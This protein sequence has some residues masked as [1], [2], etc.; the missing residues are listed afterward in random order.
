VTEEL[1]I[2]ANQ[3]SSADKFPCLI[4]GTTIE[5]YREVIC[6]EQNKCCIRYTDNRNHTVIF[7]VD[8][9][10]TNDGNPDM[11]SKKISVK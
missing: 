6:V 9:S 7:D 4:F 3:P 2:K 11:C 10:S 8:L 5:D 1:I